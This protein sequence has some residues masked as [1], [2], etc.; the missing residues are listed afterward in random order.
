[1]KGIVLAGGSGTRLHPATLSINKQLLPVYDKPMIY[2]PVSVLMLA[3][4]REIL[5]ISS[6]EHLDNYKRLFGT[7]EQF[8]L[9]F[10]Y[11]V[12]PRPEGLAQ[13]FVIGRD[14]VGSD[15]VAL[16][17]GDNL[18]FGAGMSELLGRAAARDAGAT[19]FAYHVENPQAYGVVSLDP[20]GRPTR[21]VEKPREPDST[22]AVTG[23]YFYDNQVL[24]I[25][26]RVEP[27]ARGELEITSVNAAYLER[28]QLAV[29]RMGRGYAWLDT[30][31]HDSLLEAS[32]FVRTIQ[33]RQGLQVACLE[34]IAYLQ[35]FIG[36][37]QLVARGE[38]FAKTA[39][40]Q[41]LLRL[42]RET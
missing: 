13:A 41:N 7:G 28:G 18:F 23:L 27:S 24:D 8:G 38:L 31:T 25:A 22:W 3:G 42:A 6:P 34:E 33:N 21:I 2:Y 39:Y 5:I 14:F 30:G 4:I 37:D 35:G 1:M 40:G 9:T 26:A 11:A 12:Q 17:L 36:R 29:E 19:I 20:Q 32:E 16:I 15:P 10:S